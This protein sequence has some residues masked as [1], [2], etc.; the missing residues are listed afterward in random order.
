MRKCSW[1]DMVRP[2]DQ[3]GVQLQKPP[4]VL[5]LLEVK[6][7]RSERSAPVREGWGLSGLL[8]LWGAVAFPLQGCGSGTTSFFF[9]RKPGEDL[10]GPQEGWEQIPNALLSL[11]MTPG[12]G[13]L[14]V[15]AGGLSPYFRDPGGLQDG[16]EE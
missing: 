13:G 6:V 9:F 8:P 11:P 10:L 7:Y 1:P 5:W 14:S 2:R 4:L 12:G 15:L 16:G 3:P